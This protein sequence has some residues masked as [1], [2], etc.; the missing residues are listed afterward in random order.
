MAGVDGGAGMVCGE[1]MTRVE[2]S[3]AYKGLRKE[4]VC[5]VR[6]MKR[7]AWH[8]LDRPVNKIDTGDL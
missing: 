6:M 7:M 8:K 2:M 3:D 5:C 4:R 1:G